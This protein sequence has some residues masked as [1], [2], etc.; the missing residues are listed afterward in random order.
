MSSLGYKTHAFN[1]VL[2]E[3]NG[4]P[5]TSMCSAHST[6]DDHLRSA[7]PFC[8][9]ASC[10]SYSATL[11]AL[12]CLEPHPSP[13]VQNSKEPVQ[14]AHRLVP[15]PLMIPPSLVA[16][17]FPCIFALSQMGSVL[18]VSEWWILGIETQQ[19]K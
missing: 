17:Y 13:V 16:H 10:L 15:I 18:V 2:V 4:N 12:A 7:V 3:V 1:S 5:D 14:R 6:P 11:N 19:W 8:D 9:S